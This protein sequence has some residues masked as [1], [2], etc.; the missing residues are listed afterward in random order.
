MELNRAKPKATK[1]RRSLSPVQEDIHVESL[2]SISNINRE[3]CPTTYTI[4][5]QQSTDFEM[6]DDC[7]LPM[8][9][10][11]TEESTITF[12]EIKS[13]DVIKSSVFSALQI[14]TASLSEQPH[15]PGPSINLNHLSSLDTD[16]GMSETE[17]ASINAHGEFDSLEDI[18]VYEV[19]T[20]YQSA[21]TMLTANYPHVFLQLRDGQIINIENG[22]VVI[23][24]A[25]FSANKPEEPIASNLNS[26][27]SSQDRP[28]PLHIDSEYISSTQEST[29]Q[30]GGVADDVTNRPPLGVLNQSLL[31]HEEVVVAETTFEEVEEEVMREVRSLISNPP[32]EGWLDNETHMVY[33]T[34][35]PA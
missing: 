9:I 6:I 22:E 13:N 8:L 35:E 4:S 31:G 16:V 23:S 32:P 20:E 10:E 26:T 12:D 19:V 2:A 17:V 29:V 14:N 34:N 24:L 11:D 1:Q 7:A 15:A 21:P 30:Q 5:S 3:N 33:N 27:L 28:R 18:T 25:Q